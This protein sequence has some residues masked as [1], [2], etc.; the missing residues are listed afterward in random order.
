MYDDKGWEGILRE[1]N[2]R[3]KKAKKKR[4]KKRRA[5]SR[6]AE[7]RV[8]NEENEDVDD[9]PDLVLCDRSRAEHFGRGGKKKWNRGGNSRMWCKN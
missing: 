8:E 7:K 5:G 3:G 9:F 6:R 1:D 4:K 2:R